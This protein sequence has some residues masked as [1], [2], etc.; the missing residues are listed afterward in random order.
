MQLAE[1]QIILAF[2]QAEKEVEDLHQQTREGIETTR[3]AGN[4]LEQSPEKS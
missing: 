2:E 4:R 1:K 3:L